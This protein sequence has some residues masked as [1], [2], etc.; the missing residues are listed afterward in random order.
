MKKIPLFL[1]S[2]SIL[3]IYSSCTQKMYKDYNLFQKGMDSLKN[4]DYKAPIIQNNDGLSI[5]IFS[6]TLSQDQVAVFNMGGGTAAGVSSG[7]LSGVSGIP[8]STSS[9]NTGQNYQVDI[10]GEINIPIIGN[11]KATG[12]TA[13]EVRKDL[14]GKLTPFVK[15]PIVIVKYIGIKVNVLGA[16]MHPGIQTFSSLNPTIIDAIAQ[17]GDFADGAKRKDVYLV[18]DINGKRSTYK[19]D[20][21]SDA[22]IF[23]SEAFQLV[24]NDLIYVPSNDLKLKL[25][26]QDPD[27]QKKIQLAQIVVQAISAAAVVINTYFLLKRF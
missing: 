21:V 4:Y 3:I 8:S 9:N 17:A 12:L 27:L 5:Q 10:N 1:I 25:V 14:I 15:D 19:L 24:Q 2:L 7:G 6:A 22:A 26:N 23:N 13:E 20:F 18:R 11:I 16:V